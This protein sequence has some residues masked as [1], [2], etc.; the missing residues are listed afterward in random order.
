[1]NI[2][3]IYIHT[4]IH[5][6]IELGIYMYIYNDYVYVYGRIYTYRRKFHQMCLDENILI[7]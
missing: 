1:M 3:H 6:R 5:C 2:I 4:Y 7:L